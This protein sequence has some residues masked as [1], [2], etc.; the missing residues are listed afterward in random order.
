MS[1]TRDFANANTLIGPYE[2]WVFGPGRVYTEKKTEPLP[3]AMV[4]I[5][6]WQNP[7]LIGS[8]SNELGSE[9]NPIDNTIGGGGSTNRVKATAAIGSPPERFPDGLTILPYVFRSLEGQRGFADI[10][11]L[12][13]ISDELRLAV[14]SADRLE[15]LSNEPPLGGG[16]GQNGPVPVTLRVNHPIPESR[17]NHDFDPKNTKDPTGLE[18]CKTALKIGKP[19]IIVGVIDD[20]LPFA[21]KNFRGSDGGSRIEYCWLQGSDSNGSEGTSVA[22][23]KELYGSDIEYLIEKYG[24]DEDSIYADPE[25]GAI[26]ADSDTARNIFQSYTHG[27]HVMERACGFEPS[28]TGYE[29]RDAVRIVAVQLPRTSLRD[30]SGFGKDMFILSGVHYILDRAERVARAVNADNATVLI[31]IS[32]GISGGPK[33]GRY[34]L[35]R[36]L[37]EIVRAYTQGNDKS[38]QNGPNGSVFG[39]V[40]IFLPSGNNFAS[41]MHAH[42]QLDHET[43]QGFVNWRIQ[44]NDRTANYL[45]AWF[46]AFPGMST[47]D[48]T[49]ALKLRLEMPNGEIVSFDADAPDPDTGLRKSEITTDSG[50]IIG[51]MSLDWSAGLWR[52]MVILAP[53][54]HE[55]TDE[56]NPA[57]VAPSG[58][59]TVRFTLKETAEEVLVQPVAIRCIVQRDEDPAG[60]NNGGRQSYFDTPTEA[61]SDDINLYRTHDSLGRR[62][63]QED[64]APERG[65]GAI[66]GYGLVNGWA[67]RDV[68][69]HQNRQIRYAVAGFTA[70][71]AHDEK[72]K[73]ADRVIVVEP[74]TYSSAGDR[75]PH[76][77]PMIDL[78]GLSDRSV[79]LAGVRGAGTR[80]GSTT[81]LVGTSAAAP[82]VLRANILAKLG[83][84]QPHYRDIGA[85]LGVAFVV[86]RTD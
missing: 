75:E 56:Y 15:P 6:E 20:G 41:Q 34:Q 2:S 19:L 63:A 54:E 64:H 39:A 60:T 66:S 80:S 29:D 43:P 16:Q 58:L 44:P 86:E 17:I 52:Y 77:P 45:E 81:V 35:E 67:T 21:H 27:A 12:V 25:S 40:Q 13:S 82:S 33:N 46:N 79:N 74:A 36:A 70:G 59:W 69:D 1:A 68:S 47:T 50:E 8:I 14:T 42:I 18:A 85:R 4:G 48:A 76:K 84:D 32:L 53:T 71:K 38:E 11:G 49:D 23:G 9:A 7:V 65:R 26:T 22:F 62:I 28:D 10:Q 31:N 55:E 24:D 30:T 3:T 83:K 57:P 61:G 51:Q 72:T 5:G 73:S 37:D 78:S